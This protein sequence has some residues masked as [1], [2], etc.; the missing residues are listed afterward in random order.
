MRE[1]EFLLISVKY[2]QD[3]RNLIYDSQELAELYD[4][5]AEKEF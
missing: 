1:N 4:Y 3:S 2:F 5:E